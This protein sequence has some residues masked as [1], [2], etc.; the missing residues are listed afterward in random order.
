MPQIFRQNF[1][2]IVTVK[3]IQSL[4]FLSDYSVKQLLLKC[5]RSIRTTKLRARILFFQLHESTF[6]V[7]G[8]D[9]G[10]GY[11]IVLNAPTSPLNSEMIWNI[12]LFKIM[13]RKKFFVKFKSKLGYQE[14][15]GFY[16]LRQ[17]INTWTVSTHSSFI[18]Y[19][20]ILWSKGAKCLI[21][22][23]GQSDLIKET[24]EW[25]KS[26]APQ[27]RD[28]WGKSTENFF[29]APSKK[30]NQ[31]K[32][33]D[34]QSL[35]SVLNELKKTKSELD[36]IK[37]VDCILAGYD[38]YSNHLVTYEDKSFKTDRFCNQ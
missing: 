27:K 1:I 18:D 6:S 38:T 3:L 36:L 35:Q 8:R 25:T 23:K 5:F 2:C 15:P 9:V 14:F 34:D 31:R 19:M 24:E 4:R 12:S 11:C 28:S 37:S 21:T 22:C 17:H 32:P 30:Q 33:V 13:A 26:L 7:T 20:N 16:A 29:W 10:S